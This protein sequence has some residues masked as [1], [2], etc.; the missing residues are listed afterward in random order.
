MINP[1]SFEIQYHSV[2]T[3][4]GTNLSAIETMRWKEL[5]MY[6]AFFMP[7]YHALYCLFH[8]YEVNHFRWEIIIYTLPQRRQILGLPTKP[9]LL[10]DRNYRTLGALSIDDDDLATH[11]SEAFNL[12]TLTGACAFMTPSRGELES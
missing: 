6:K 7:V 3:R 1:F 9:T 10:S 2:I 12:T 5:F 4:R 8:Y 11:S